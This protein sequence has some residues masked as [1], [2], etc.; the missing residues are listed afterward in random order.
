M[1]PNVRHRRQRRNRPGGP[2]RPPAATNAMTLAAAAMVVV[3]AA[4]VLAAVVLADAAAAVTS[5]DAAHY[6]NQFAVRVA[7]AGDDRGQAD[8][9]AKK[10]GFVNRGQVSNYYLPLSLSSRRG[11]RKCLPPPVRTVSPPEKCI[12]FRRLS[13]SRGYGGGGKNNAK[14]F[15]I[16]G[17]NY[18]KCI[19]HNGKK[20]KVIGPLSVPLPSDRSAYRE[21]SFFWGEGCEER[22]V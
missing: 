4:V 1:A 22:G 8:R 21:I 16:L 14:R 7:G 3:L 6:T 20:K 13:S 5:A 15:L 17:S 10:H 11:I 19:G 2:T 9:L 12:R 18:N